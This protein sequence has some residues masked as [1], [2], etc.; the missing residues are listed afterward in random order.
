MGIDQE[1]VKLLGELH[2]QFFDSAIKHNIT[3]VEWDDFFSRIT[4]VYKTLGVTKG[5]FIIDENGC[6]WEDS[7]ET[8][9]QDKQWSGFL[10]DLDNELTDITEEWIELMGDKDWDHYMKFLDKRT[11]DLLEEIKIYC[12]IHYPTDGGHNEVEDEVSEEDREHER[13]MSE[14]M[15]QFESLP[16]PTVG[17]EEKKEEWYDDVSIEDIIKMLYDDDDYG[18]S[19]GDTTDI[20]TDG[21]S[22]ITT[23]P[24]G[25]LQ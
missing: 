17:I 8:P 4:E 6:H 7:I 22:V 24:D 11:E 14:M 23:S 2:H 18:K 16:L 3:K 13:E 25:D 19:T 10:R 12:K 9:I 15:S 1:R 5:R 20:P 21:E